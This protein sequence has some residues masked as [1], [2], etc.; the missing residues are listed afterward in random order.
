[1]DMDDLVQDCSNSNVLGMELL[2]TCT[3]QWIYASVNYAIISMDNGS[4]LVWCQAITWTSAD[5]LMIGLLLTT[6][7]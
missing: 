6:F 1:M 7:S 5:I 4:S 3:K 2:Q